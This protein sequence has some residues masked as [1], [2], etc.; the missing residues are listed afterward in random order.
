MYVDKSRFKPCRK[1]KKKK[2]GFGGKIGKMLTLNLIWIFS[3]LSLQSCF[4]FGVC[5]RNFIYT[6]TITNMTLNQ[7]KR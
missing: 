1:K 3:F 4:T 6:H 5:I 7:P 2:N